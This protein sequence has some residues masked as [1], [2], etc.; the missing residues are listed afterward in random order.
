MN[1][2]R[3]LR[4]WC[5]GLL[6][7][8]CVTFGQNDIHPTAYT[9]N[10]QG[11]T[12][13]ANVPLKRDQQR[14]ALAAFPPRLFPGLTGGE[15]W[16]YSAQGYQVSFVLNGCYYQA[17]FDQHGSYRYSLLYT[18]WPPRE[19]IPREPGDLLRRK[20]PEYQ[21]NIVTEITDG[22]KIVYLVRLASSTNIKT[23]SLCDGDIQVIAEEHISDPAHLQVGSYFEHR[24][25]Y[26]PTVLPVTV[27]DLRSNLSSSF[28]D[29]QQRRGHI[30]AAAATRPE[31]VGI[32][33]Y[34]RST[35]LPLRTV[36]NIV[37]KGSSCT[38]QPKGQIVT[39]FFKAHHQF[40][41]VGLFQH[42][43]REHRDDDFIYILPIL[44]FDH[45]AGYDQFL[46]PQVPVQDQFLVYIELN[47]L[48]I[49]ILFFQFL[50]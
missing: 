18:L 14:H 47:L 3:L 13:S 20:Y 38:S 42:P 40:V 33:V 36:Q 5:F 43:G 49:D 17:F 11:N 45:P 26:F 8:P 4:H 27:R 2:Y 41:V 31:F 9:Y 30:G 50:T 39:V 24:G 21:L 22:E 44:H 37:V 34:E 28:P 19:S 1:A 35:I 29:H 15:N 12:I 46:V 48:Q 16:F 10:D 7:V 6:L 32:I 25:S 23:V